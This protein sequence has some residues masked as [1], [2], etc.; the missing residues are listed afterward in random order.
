MK[1]FLDI[2]K[3]WVVPYN[4]QKSK[5]FLGTTGTSPNEATDTYDIPD[6]GN[7]GGG[8]GCAV[9]AAKR[10]KIAP[11]PALGV[12]VVGGHSSWFTTK[13][14]TKKFVKLNC[15]KNIKYFSKFR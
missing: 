13:K 12:V 7:G 3:K 15:V 6:G 1:N 14:Q 9:E 2:L 11:R 4:P 5:W 8:G 10:S